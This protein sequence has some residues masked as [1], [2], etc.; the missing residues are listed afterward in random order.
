[1][2]FATM[3]LFASACLSPDLQS[4]PIG[5]FTISHT[6]KHVSRGSAFRRLTCVML[7]SNLLSFKLSLTL[8]L[9]GV[10]S[11]VD[12]WTWYWFCCYCKETAL[13]LQVR[14]TS[15]MATALFLSG[16]N[17]PPR[18]T[19]QK[20]NNTAVSS[21]LTGFVA[22][23]LGEKFVSKQKIPALHCHEQILFFS[24]NWS[25]D[26]SQ[27]TAKFLFLVFSAVLRVDSFSKHLEG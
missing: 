16:N 26:L 23:D 24:H 6:P 5:D 21:I 12:S 15:L 8:L 27:S 7:Q 22:L 3:L 2:S 20:K 18:P 19:A 11:V 10:C 13:G 4:M 25:T 9:M 14:T 17:Y 1:M